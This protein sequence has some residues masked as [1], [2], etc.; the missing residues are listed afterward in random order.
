M[1]TIDFKRL[2]TLSKTY[3][4]LL[5]VKKSV[6]S[7]SALP[8]TG[9]SVGDIVMVGTT[10]PTPYIWTGSKFEQLGGGSSIETVQTISSSSTH[11]KI[12]TAKAVYNYVTEQVGNIAAVLQSVVYGN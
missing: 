6:S 5:Q 9:C 8:T 2:E 1:A 4:G 7:T 3:D 10:N 11:S 12:P